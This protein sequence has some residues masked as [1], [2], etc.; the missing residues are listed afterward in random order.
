M[1]IARISRGDT[2]CG[3]PIAAQHFEEVEQAI[4]NPSGSEDVIDVNIAKATDNF[5]HPTSQDM[6][7]CHR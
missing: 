5:T 1:P 6:R 3:A 2:L 4:V 7:D